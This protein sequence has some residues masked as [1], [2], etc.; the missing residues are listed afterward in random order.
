MHSPS[1]AVP[2]C[3]SDPVH[4]GC[5]EAL[6]Q[7]DLPQT[8]VGTILQLSLLV[9]QLAAALTAGEQPEQLQNLI[10][11]YRQVADANLMTIPWS[12]VLKDRGIEDEMA[13]RLGA[14]L[15]CQSL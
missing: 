1:T 12:T 9:E 2:P 6:N 7:T 11:R 3:L 4:R 10:N 5:A 14:L 8:M 15:S 13:A